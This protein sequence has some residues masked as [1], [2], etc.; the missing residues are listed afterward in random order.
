VRVA[1]YIFKKFYSIGI[2]KAYIVTG[3]G[4]LFLTDALA[5]KNDQ[6]SAVSMHHEQSAGFAAGA[7]SQ[8]TNS[9]SLCLVSTGCASTNCIT[10]VLNAWQDGLPVIFLSGQNFLKETTYFTGQNLRTFGQQEANIVSIVKSITNYS[11]M[12]ACAD[13][14]PQVIEE[15]IHAANFGRKGPVWIDIPLDIQNSRI[16]EEN[17][18]DS[19]K[20]I[21]HKEESHR[22]SLKK[23]IKDLKVSKRPVILIGSGV[24]HSDSIQ[25]LGSFLELNQIPLVYSSS[26]VDIYPSGNKLSIG[27][28]GSM[29]C[30]RE[31]AFTI[32]NADLILVLGN[33]LPSILTGPDYCKF[34]REAKIHVVDIDEA[35]HKKNGIRI[36]NFIKTD[37]ASFFNSMPNKKLT[38]ELSLWHKKVFHWKRLFRKY[39][40]FESDNKI[41]LYNL[42]D[43]LSNKMKNDSILITDSG[44]NEVILPTNINFS[45]RRRAIHPVSQGSMGFAIPAIIGVHQKNESQEIICVVGDGSIMM[46]LQELQ[47]ISHHKIN[48]KI[49]VINNDI[50]SIIRRRQ[51]ELFRNRTIGT[52]IDDGVSIPDFKQL[53]KTFKLNYFK[54]TR[55]RD[56]EDSLDHFLSKDGPSL[57]EI[58]GRHDQQYIEIS[59][60]KNKDRKIVRR[61]LEDQWPFLERDIFLSEMIIDVIDQ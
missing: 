5:A 8:L 52:G 50:Y 4:A 43:I 51:K 56:L 38:P 22:P 60:T 32:Q 12:I 18:L 36:D 25:S 15:A 47:T 10:P 30:S 16:S 26:S 42:A 20:I 21:G 3:R 27:S 17:A 19:P 34:G 58:Y 1:D 11:K 31:G 57:L 28:V 49:I 44:F 13:E 37:L 40:N 6:I 29:G 2:E 14:V 24:R 7:E 41:D 55:A 35:E 39:V 9:P 53:S 54:C 59:R 48:V 45:P 23:L 61:P 46:N 33:R